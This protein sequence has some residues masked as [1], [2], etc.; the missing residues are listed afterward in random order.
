M[1]KTPGVTQ[2]TID[3]LVS[4]GVYSGAINWVVE[5]GP[6]S[7][8]YVEKT[9]SVCSPSRYEVYETAAKWGS[10]VAKKSNVLL[11]PTDGRSLT[12]TPNESADIVQA[13]NST[14]RLGRVRRGYGTMSRY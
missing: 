11:Q 9:L 3:N 6:G 13:F 8:R 2:L 10:Y 1:S 5:I 7:G 12:A 4:L 14:R